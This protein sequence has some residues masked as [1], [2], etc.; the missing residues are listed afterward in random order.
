[1]SS[2]RLGAKRI[3]EGMWFAMWDARG[4]LSARV[5]MDLHE[6]LGSHLHAADSEQGPHLGTSR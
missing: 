5:Q 3:L 1:M 4:S 2:P 6:P